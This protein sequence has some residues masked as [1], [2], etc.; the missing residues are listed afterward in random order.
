MPIIQHSDAPS[1]E[2]NPGV[3][4]ATLVDSTQGTLSLHVGYL[5]INPGSRVVTHIHPDT[6]E[7]MVIAEVPFA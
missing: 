7:A 2:I 6:E 3:N 5:T 1:E 4:R